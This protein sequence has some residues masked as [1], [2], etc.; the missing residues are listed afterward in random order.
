MFSKGKH[1]NKMGIEEE[2]LCKG[3][4]IRYGSELSACSRSFVGVRVLRNP[5][6]GLCISEVEKETYA[7]SNHQCY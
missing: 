3:H 1:E 4:R 6:M 7:I 5:C 2:T